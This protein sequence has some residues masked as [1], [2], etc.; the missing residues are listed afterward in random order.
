MRSAGNVSY[1]S[2]DG[3]VFDGTA[4]TINGIEDDKEYC[5]EVTFDAKD[6]NID[7]VYIDG[8]D[9]TNETGSYTIT[10]DDKQHTVKVTDKAGNETTYTINVYKDHAFGDYVEKSRS[11]EGGTIVEEATCEHCGKTISRIRTVNKLSN[12]VTAEENVSGAFFTVVP[13][14]EGLTDGLIGGFSTD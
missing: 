12:D 4:P 1:I 8:E 13:S 2:S 14:T 7:K 5:R 9:A 11:E 3:L 6:D 10:G